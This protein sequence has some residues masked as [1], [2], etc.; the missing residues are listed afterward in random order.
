MT[1]P[2]T[3]RAEDDDTVTYRAALFEAVNPTV[4]YDRVGYG[5]DR[6]EGAEP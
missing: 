5:R 4:S 1:A 2:A 6:T 3:N